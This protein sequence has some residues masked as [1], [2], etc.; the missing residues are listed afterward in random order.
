MPK[1][2]KDLDKKLYEL[3]PEEERL[4]EWGEGVEAQE[5]MAAAMKLAGSLG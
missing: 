3:R 2:R 4:A 5:G 1:A